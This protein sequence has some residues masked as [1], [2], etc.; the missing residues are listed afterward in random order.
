MFFLRDAHRATVARNAK[1][2]TLLDHLFRHPTIS[3]KGVAK[4]MGCTFSTASKLVTDF[5]S[6]GWLKEVTGN[7]RNRLWRYQPYLDLF[8]REA[9]DDHGRHQGGLS[10]EHAGPPVPSDLL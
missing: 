2:L 4:A 8:H 10:N 6:Q 5:E 9:L 1:A 3:V 7:E